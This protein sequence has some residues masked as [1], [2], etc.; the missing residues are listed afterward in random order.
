MSKTSISQKELKRQLCYEP[1]TGI[2]KWKI[3]KRG[4]SK[5]GDIIKCLDNNGYLVARI[6]QK[7]Y[8]LHRLAWLYV[9][10]YFPE[11]EIDHINNIRKDNRIV[12]L[13]E[14]SHSCN[15]RNTGNYKNNFSGVKGVYWDKS[16][17]KWTAAIVVLERKTMLGRF[18]NFIEAVCVRYAA[19]QCLDWI[20]CKKDSPAYLF[21]S[22][23]GIVK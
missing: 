11:H 4:P 1:G 5:A 10:G 9:N 8:R 12:N 23:N 21:L 18:T 19:E 6:N 22:K 16:R 20:K 14:V 3:T 13:R 7:N 17:K 15:L 2:F